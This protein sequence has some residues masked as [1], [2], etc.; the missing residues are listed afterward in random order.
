M[1][2]Y[3]ITNLRTGKVYVGQTVQS[4]SKMRWYSHLADARGGKSGHLYESIRK[5]GAEQFKWEVI[6]TGETVD[7]LNKLEIKWI[8]HYRA[9][10]E[11]YNHRDGGDNSLHSKESIERMKIAQKKRHAEK[12]A[13]G[14]TR[15]DGGAMLGKSHPGKGKPNKKWSNEMKAEHSIRCLTRKQR[16]ITDELKESLAHCKGKTWKLINGKR[17]WMETI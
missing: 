16:K 12:P 3:K 11:I 14:W 4:N 9:L 13:G 5:Y 17:V 6:D 15:R 2:I 10:G 7:E 1:V 8:E